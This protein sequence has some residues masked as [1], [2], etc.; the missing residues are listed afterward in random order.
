MR[1]LFIVAGVA[2]LAATSALA[3]GP[4]VPLIERTKLF[5]NSSRA[6]G[7]ATPARRRARRC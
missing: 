6:A 3:A 5:G 4:N 7:W 1:H 2:A